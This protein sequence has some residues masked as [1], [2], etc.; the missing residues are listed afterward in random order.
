[1]LDDVKKQ[2]SADESHQEHCI[3]VCIYKGTE[4]MTSGFPCP[5]RR[6]RDSGLPAASPDLSRLDLKA[7]QSPAF[8]GRTVGRLGGGDTSG[9]TGGIGG[10][11][12]A[13]CL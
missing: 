10:N 3:L 13:P 6:A 5:C 11:H 12:P 9:D 4:P 8:I 7:P 2:R 1:M